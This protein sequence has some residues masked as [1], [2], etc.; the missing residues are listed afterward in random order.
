MRDPVKDT[1]HNYRGKLERKDKQQ[2]PGTHRDFR[3]LT[4]ALQPFVPLQLDELRFGL[5][6]PDFDVCY[7]FTVK[8]SPEPDPI[9]IFGVIYATLEFWL[10]HWMKM[11][12][13]LDTAIEN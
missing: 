13:W 11:G 9:T 10:F 8:G 3:P 2:S 12:R 1:V 4:S 6:D 7:L 5:K